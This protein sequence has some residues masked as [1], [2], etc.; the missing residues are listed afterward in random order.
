MAILAAQ[1]LQGSG[2]IGG[3]VGI[4]W[5][6]GMAF[7]AVQKARLTTEKIKTEKSGR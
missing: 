2:A 1:L 3:F 6:G 4:I 5:I 7:G